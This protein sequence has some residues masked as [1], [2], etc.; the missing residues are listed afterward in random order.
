MPSRKSNLLIILSTS[1]ALNSVNAEMPASAAQGGSVFADSVTAKIPVATAPAKGFGAFDTPIDKSATNYGSLNY[2]GSLGKLGVQAIDRCKNYV[3]TGDVA[4]DQ[5]CAGLNY[6][7][8]NCLQTTATQNKIIGSV[9]NVPVASSNCVGAYGSSAGV[10]ELSAKDKSMITHFG[11]STQNAVSAA[12]ECIEV[13]KIVRP[14]T[15][16]I[17]NCT[18]NTNYTEV[19]CTQDLNPQCLLRGGDLVST[20]VNK[21]SLSHAHITKTDAA[22]VYNYLMSVDYRCNSEAS[23]SIS[24]EV[25]DIA[26]GASITLTVSN[27]D[28]AAAIGV[29]GT[30]VY[31]GYPNAGPQYYGGFFPTS[32]KSFQIGYSWT[33]KVGT[34]DQQFYAN[35]KL[36]DYC[37]SGYSPISQSQLRR[38]YRG[39]SDYTPNNILGFFCNAEGKFLMNR[40]EGIG[41]WSGTIPSST[42]PLVNGVNTIEVYWG[43]APW[44]GC[45]NVTVQGVITNKVP[46]CDTLWTNNCATYETSSGM[47]LGNPE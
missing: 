12:E 36:L 45:G 11:K 9:A 24:F 20:S 40:H 22:G 44:E 14:A 39:P 33:E 1:L 30:T 10:F 28:D 23:G 7:A 29:N 6:M 42:W 21:G 19:A 5:E 31:A 47:T 4:Q 25:Q 15:T 43:T 26:W 2:K 17:F 18:K 34:T 32:A 41:T 27:L 13:E 46:A 3:P 38:G 16:E 35:T 8:N 37:P